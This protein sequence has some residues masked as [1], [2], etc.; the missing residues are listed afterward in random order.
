MLRLLDTQYQRG[1]QPQ[2][3]EHLAMMEFNQNQA[4]YKAELMQQLQQLQSKNSSLNTK[5]GTAGLNAWQ[6]KAP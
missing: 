1:L 6:Q 2:S 3:Y 4:K 5:L